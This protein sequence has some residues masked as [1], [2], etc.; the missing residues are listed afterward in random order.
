MDHRYTPPSSV[1]ILRQTTDAGICQVKGLVCSW[2]LNP[3]LSLS[4]RASQSGALRI[5]QG[6]VWITFG[7]AAQDCTVRAGDYFLSQGEQLRVAAGQ[8]L[9]MESFALGVAASA[10]FS[11]EPDV[12]TT[13]VPQLFRDLHDL[14]AALGLATAAAGRLLRGV[15]VG[16]LGGVRA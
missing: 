16:L 11:W 15:T 6:R 10:G 8:V 5:G 4:L 1:H 7:D 3:G 13:G 14:R 12:V 9:V 2:T